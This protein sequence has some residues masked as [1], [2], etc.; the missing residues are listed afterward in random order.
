M[1]NR[2]GRAAESSH[3]GTGGATFEM[4]GGVLG[5]RRWGCRAARG[6]GRRLPRGRASSCCAAA[7]EGL[8]ARCV[9]CRAAGA[10]VWDGAQGCRRPARIWDGEQGGGGWGV[11]EWGARVDL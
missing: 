3:R 8:A 2:R 1:P 9:G 10:G 4:E 5:R 6:L 7:L 11:G